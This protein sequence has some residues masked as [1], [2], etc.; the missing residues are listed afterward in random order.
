MTA[1]T[2]TCRGKQQLALFSDKLVVRT[3]K[4]DIAVP[5]GAI[6]HV[7][8]SNLFTLSEVDACKLVEQADEHVPALRARLVSCQGGV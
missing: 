8:V 1:C 7:A 4:A 6:K 3:T 5:W 2:P